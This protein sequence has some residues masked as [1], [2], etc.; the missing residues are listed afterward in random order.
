MLVLALPV[1][2]FYVQAGY[3][4]ALQVPTIVHLAHVNEF[5]PPPPGHIFRQPLAE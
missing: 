2:L 1:L 3:D 5:L 4:T